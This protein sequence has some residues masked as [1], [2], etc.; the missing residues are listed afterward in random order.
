VLKAWAGC[1]VA[2]GIWTTNGLGSG[3]VVYRRNTVKVIAPNDPAVLN[4]FDVGITCVDI[5]GEA[6]RDG[7]PLP[8]PNLFE[9]NILIGNASLVQFGSSYG[10][11]GSSYF[12]RTRLIRIPG[13]DEYFKP[14]RLGYWYSS[15]HDNRM[16]DTTAEGF[17]FPVTPTYHGSSGYMEVTYG[18]SHRAQF[19]SSSGDAI[20][21]VTVI[22]LIDGVR[23]ET[24]VTDAQGFATFDVLEE[25]HVQPGSGIEGDLAA[26]PEHH[27]Y[28]ECKF[29]VDAYD[30]VTLTI[31]DVK[32][33]DQIVLASQAGLSGGV[34][35]GITVAVV[36]VVA[37]VAFAVVWFGVKKKSL[38]DICRR[39]EDDEGVP[40]ATP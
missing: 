12:Y 29:S 35:A 38:G 10:V 15:T 33:A 13:L 16:I 2:R 39:E 37:A 1:P 23:T 3:V 27:V 7:K 9:D 6:G 36:I 22:M 32:V 26:K 18:V 25:E 11:G 20:A 31:A 19:V 17:T 30:P 5:N 24:F 4:D 21:D 40:P 8:D 34:I 14:I 28:A